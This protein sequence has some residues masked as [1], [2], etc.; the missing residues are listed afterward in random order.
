MKMTD[1]RIKITERRIITWDC[2]KCPANIGIVEAKNKDNVCRTSLKFLCTDCDTEYCLHWGY[3]G[4]ETWVE[5]W[6]AYTR[7]HIHRNNNPEAQP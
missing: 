4:F 6:E 1:H 5:E 3:D 2:V 7:R